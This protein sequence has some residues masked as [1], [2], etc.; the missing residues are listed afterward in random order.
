MMVCACTTVS[1]GSRLPQ[2]VSKINELRRKAAL[3]DDRRRGLD[4][5]AR[6]GELLAGI[7]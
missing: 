4:G 1:G 2:A 5:A 7:V 6:L 3:S